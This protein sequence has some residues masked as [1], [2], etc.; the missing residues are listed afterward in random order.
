MPFSKLVTQFADLVSDRVVARLEPRIAALEATLARLET[1]SHGSRATFVGHNRVLVRAVVHGANIAWL[2]AADDLLLS[3]WFIATGEYDRDLTDYVVRTIRP[4]SHCIDVGANFG[5]FSCLMARFAP[6]G[7]VVGIEADERV[8]ALARDNVAINGFNGTTRVI[9]AAASDRP[10]PLTLYR[11]STRS[12]NTSIARVGRGLTELLGEAE[13]EAFTV[14]GVT[15][16]SLLDDFDGRIDLIKIDVE[17][18]EP[19]VFRGAR[20]T[21]ARN[22]QIEIVME[23]SPGQMQAAGFDLRSF[24]DDLDGMGLTPW[25]MAPHTLEPLTWEALLALPYQPGVVL[26]RPA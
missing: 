5:Y 23:W 19:L 14:A 26:K 9:H 6:Q 10:E 13:E 24:A 2:V 7:R 25:A 15:L 18:A 12:G 3:P 22:P 16:D 8:F 11:R 1:F 4:D 20:E 17:G 21:V